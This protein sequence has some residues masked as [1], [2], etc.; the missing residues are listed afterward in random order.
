MPRIS[1]HFP[2]TVSVVGQPSAA[3]LEELG[4]VVEDALA[5]RLRLARNEL[6]SAVGREPARP[7]EAGESLDRDRICVTGPVYRVPSYDG[8][9]ALRPVRLETAQPRPRDPALLPDADLDSEYGHA[10]DWLLSHPR[11]DPAYAATRTY[12][13]ELEGELHRRQGAAGRTAAGHGGAPGGASGGS[14]APPVAAPATPSAPGLPGLPLVLPQTGAPP[15][16]DR[17]LRITAAHA[18]GAYGEHDLPFLLGERGFRMVVTSSG[19]GAHQLTGRGIDA[20]AFHPQTGEVWLI[21]N[22]ASGYLDPAEGAKATALGKNLGRSL[23]EAVADVRA[24]PDFPEKADLVKRLEGSLAAVRAGTPIPAG[25]KVK[26]K[27]TNAGGY[28]SGARKLP[29]GVEFEDLVGPGARVARGTD[30]AK[31]EAAGVK[32]GRP[33]SHAQT[34]AM[35]RKVGGAVSRQPVRIPVKVRMVSGLRGG[36]VGLA[37]ILAALAWGAVAARIRQDWET[38]KVKE[39]TEPQFAKMEPEIRSRIENRLDELV[40]LR[41]ARPGTTLYAVVSTLVTI[42]RRGPGESL[43]SAEA[44]LASVTVSAERV[45]RTETSREKGGNRWTTGEWQHDLIRTSYSIELEPFTKE[46]LTA[47]LDARIAA[48]EEAQASTSAPASEVPASQRRRDDLLAARARLER[49]P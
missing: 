2:I 25:L 7:A 46:E 29:P 45:E 47:V 36:G 26:L 24:M 21:D 18:G 35:R 37:K 6:A 31:A 33:A 42:E 34:E 4:R 10:R 43:T 41:L 40:D 5:D 3:D 14:T 23:E 32:P 16:A 28:T 39:W 17:P 1:C 20:I 49:E 44:T 30:I 27:V 19:P 9:G 48:E 15:P 12:L 38:G 22:K 11:T 13:E 8:G